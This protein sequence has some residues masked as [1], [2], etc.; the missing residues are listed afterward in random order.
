MLV[1]TGRLTKN[2]E[3]DKVFKYGRSSYNQNIGVKVI[4]N[5]NLINRLGII[6]S[7]KVSKK[8]T[9][10]NKFKRSIKEIFRLIESKLKTGYDILVIALPGVNNKTYQEIT[11]IFDQ[12]L[13]K[14]KMFK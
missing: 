6:I 10:R 8:A 4:L 5:E 3:F 7:C 1:K 11:E 12:G 9:D 14:L 2:K 13:K